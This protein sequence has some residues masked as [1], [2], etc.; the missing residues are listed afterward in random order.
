MATPSL[1]NIHNGEILCF[2]S[3][4]IAHIHSENDHVDGF[5]YLFKKG[6]QVADID[7]TSGSNFL[8]IPKFDEKNI[9]V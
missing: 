6:V 4:A 7:L 3:S 5:D 9:Y 1:L 8:D 2:L